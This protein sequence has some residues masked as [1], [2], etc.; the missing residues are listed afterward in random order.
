MY[1]MPR[2]GLMMARSVIMQQQRHMAATTKASLEQ[3][4]RVADIMTGH[5]P[6]FLTTPHPFQ[7]YSKDIVFIDNIRSKR[8]QGLGQYALQ[9]GIT[10]LYF[11][12]R[13]SSTRMEL[14]NLVKDPEESCVKIRWRFVSKPGLIRFILFPFR[15]HS[16]EIWTD[17]ISSFY[18]NT[19]GKIYCHVC[20]NIDHEE[21]TRNVEK[22][23]KNPLVSKGVHV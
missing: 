9:V 19:E 12:I 3:L 8:V 7:I 22:V 4:T 13:Y 1:S 14:L 17:G 5:L 20:D 18:V 21:D 15:F 11:T 6:K 16:D 10:K 2:F 23:V